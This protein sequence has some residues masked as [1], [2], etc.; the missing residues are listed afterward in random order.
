[1][2]VGHI[3]PVSHLDLVKDK[4]YHLIL[5]HM[6]FSN[7]TYKEFY[8]KQC[9]MGHFVTLDNADFEVGSEFKK[10]D[11]VKLAI[12]IGVDEVMAPEQY[13]DGKKTVELAREFV[14]YVYKEL[15]GDVPFGIF[16]VIHGKD[17]NDYVECYRTVCNLPEVSTVGISIR[18]TRDLTI[19]EAVQSPSPT[20]QSVYNRIELIRKLPDKDCKTH[21]LLGFH[22][23]V[24]LYH[25]KKWS[26]IRSADSS[27]AFVHGSRGIR[28]TKRGLPGEKIQELIDF[29]TEVTNEKLL[30][31][32]KFNIDVIERWFAGGEKG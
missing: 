23:A 22:D 5:A 26:F 4:E 16:V 2:K 12:D 32:I 6:A 27:S 20:L 9:E 3:V 10:E 28:Y 19:P 21:H 7:K 30:D 29:E 25:Q 1:M 14:K 15:K 31:D 13:Q 18:P 24:E 8:K 17:L 11:L